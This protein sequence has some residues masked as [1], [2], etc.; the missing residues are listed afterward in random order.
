MS[1]EKTI[2][3]FIQ[4]HGDEDL[5]TEFKDLNVE[6]LSISG[7]PGEL[8]VM[9]LTDGV[10]LDVAILNSLQRYYS[11]LNDI[12]QNILYDV[13]AGIMKPIYNS[14][15]ISFTNGGFKYTIPKH[16]RNFTLEAGVHENCSEV[17]KLNVNK[18]DPYNIANLKYT[19]CVKLRGYDRC[20][21]YGIVVVASSDPSD[22][23]GRFT[24][25]SKNSNDDINNSNI[26]ISRTAQNHWRNK[27]YDLTNNKHM[28]FANSILEKII[29]TKHVKLSELTNFFHI[30]GFS[31]I[32]IIDP[33]CRNVITY[34]YSPPYHD[35][36]L[37][38]KD[39]FKNAVYQ[40]M[41]QRPDAVKNPKINGLPL[42]RM[43]I[44]NHAEIDSA[45]IANLPVSEND[46]EPQINNYICD[47]ADEEDKETCL[48]KYFPYWFSRP[49][50]AGYKTIKHDNRIKSVGSKTRK[51]I[52]N[53]KNK[54]RKNR[55]KN[56][57]NKFRK[58]RI[59]N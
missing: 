58:S 38:G 43:E 32:Y 49:K 28:E 51:S 12:D 31:K 36:M 37:K 39:R 23:E 41:E 56:I 20:P 7:R 26:T 5:N 45:E 40:I 14:F 50:T 48:Q 34:K 3:I 15:N 13:S 54:S 30:L 44:Q 27:I 9:Q 18:R 22:N 2:T 53:R 24:L 59:K 17:C 10:S 4:G 21:Y 29:V 6:L 33:T 42:N 47:N 55:I 57:K 11:D 1:N 46:I 35:I 25:Q 8:G 19:K 52:K 16:E